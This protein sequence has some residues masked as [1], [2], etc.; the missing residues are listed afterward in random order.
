MT[1][2]SGLTR[3]QKFCVSLLNFSLL[4]L[5][6]KLNASSTD[7]C[8]LLC[9]IGRRRIAQKVGGRQKVGGGGPGPEESGLQHAHWLSELRMHVP[10]CDLSLL[11]SSL[12]PIPAFPCKPRVGYGS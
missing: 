2:R 10:S 6:M 7:F 3:G 1:S 8:C 5:E 12:R 9:K 11:F 4:R